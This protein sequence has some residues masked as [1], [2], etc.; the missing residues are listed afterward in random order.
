MW[1]AEVEIRHQ[2]TYIAMLKAGFQRSQRKGSFG[3]RAII[4][5]NM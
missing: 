2:V 1:L 4:D 5:M 3:L